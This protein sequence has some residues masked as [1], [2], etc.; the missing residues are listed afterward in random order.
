MSARTVAALSKAET[1]ARIRKY[2]YGIES[3]ILELI[4]LQLVGKPYAPPFLT[5]VEDDS[6]S[7]LCNEPD[8]RRQLVVAV[9]AKRTEDVAGQAF[10]VY[11][12]EGRL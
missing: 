11:S 9:A 1:R 3:F 5:H 10:R 2:L 4:R 12:H 6:R 8:R 7:F